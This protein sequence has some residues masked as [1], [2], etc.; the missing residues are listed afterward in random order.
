MSG[1]LILVV[2]P[3]GAG[4]DTLIDG[5]RRALA[6]DRRFVFPRRV[7]TR[8]SDAGGEAHDASGIDE[9]RM[10]QRRGVFALSWDAHGLGYGIPR[11]IE[12]HLTAAQ[13][14]VVNVSR[15]VIPA[16]RMRYQPLAI[17]EV[18]APVSVLAARLAA[19]GRESLEEI[20][21]RLDRS[22]AVA[23]EGPDVRRVENS[24]SV[25]DGVSAMLNALNELCSLSSLRGA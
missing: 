16:A 23:V 15:A 20:A 21:R 10:A 2:G 24:G 18:W 9:F 8:P 17:I 13:H 6:D 12:E 5:A 4:K 25:A 1:T 11:A 7:I 14:V 22:S 19:R 3:S